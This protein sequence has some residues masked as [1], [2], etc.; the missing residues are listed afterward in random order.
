MRTK[1]NKKTLAAGAVSLAMAA[2]GIGTASA[3]TIPVLFDPTGSGGANG[4]LVDTFD[5]APGNALAV[6]S[7]PLSQDPNNPTPFTLLAQAKLSTLRLNG[8]NVTPATLNPDNITFVTGFGE[9]GY[10]FLSPSGNKA[11]ADL[12]VDPNAGPNFF[13]IWV[14]TT[15][16][17]PANDLSGYGFNSGTL[18][19]KGR[20][21]SGTG[22]FA[23]NLDPNT[24]LPVTASLDQAGTNDW[25]KA[26]P[27]GTNQLTVTGTGSTT[28]Q[29]TVDISGPGAYVNP[30]YFPGGTLPQQFKIAMFDTQNTVPFDQVDPSTCFTMEGDPDAT[31]NTNGPGQPARCNATAFTASGSID[32]TDPAGTHNPALGAINGASGP[33][34]LFETDAKMSFVPEPAG[35]A[36][37]GAGLLGLGFG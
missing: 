18:I 22:E 1:L 26:G 17:S 10:T 24:G 25:V 31:G 13:E 12:T 29:M 8:A 28:L 36:L 16:G 34:F 27:G 2:A 15:G 21:T 32:T 30:N 3:G 19:L 5:W 37:L 14:N 9:T 23:I 7:V 33:D 35:I 4:I 20:L 11:F 6:G